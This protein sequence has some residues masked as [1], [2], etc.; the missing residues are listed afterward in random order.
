MGLMDGGI[1]HDIPVDL[2]PEDLRT[3]N[4]EFLIYSNFADVDSIRI[5]RLDG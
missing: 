3:P 1:E 2:I 4:C 5:E